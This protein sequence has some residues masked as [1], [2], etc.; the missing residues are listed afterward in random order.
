MNRRAGS[1][2]RTVGC[3]GVSRMSG[4]RVLNRGRRRIRRRVMGREQVTD[5]GYS[6]CG[7]GNDRH[8]RE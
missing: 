4:G 6:R 2:V 1:A 8:A 3:A 7:A 5:P